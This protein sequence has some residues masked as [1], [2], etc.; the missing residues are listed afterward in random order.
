MVLSPDGE[1]LVSYNVNSRSWDSLV[2]NADIYRPRF[3]WMK[4]EQV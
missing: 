2:E 3:F 1:W 4:I